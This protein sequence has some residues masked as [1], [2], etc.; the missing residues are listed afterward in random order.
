MK[1]KGRYSANAALMFNSWFKD[2]DIC[3]HDHNLTEHGAMQL[4]KDFTTNHAQGVVKFY[5]HTKE[6]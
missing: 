4:I 2:I 5:L 3:L 6:E 1:Q